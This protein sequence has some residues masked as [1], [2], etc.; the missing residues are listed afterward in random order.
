VFYSRLVAPT[1]RGAEFTNQAV[2]TR[3]VTYKDSY[4]PKRKSLL[5]GGARPVESRRHSFPPAEDTYSGR[6]DRKLE[7]SRIRHDSY[8]DDVWRQRQPRL[9]H[10]LVNWRDRWKSL[11]MCM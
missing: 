11:K 10:E 7:H 6:L 3:P 9:M 5:R 1:R 8:V 2:G 4:A